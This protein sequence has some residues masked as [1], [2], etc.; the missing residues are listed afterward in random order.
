MRHKIHDIGNLGTKVLF[1]L[2]QATNSTIAK[3]VGNEQPLQSKRKNCTVI[4][5]PVSNLR[6]AVG[7][8]HLYPT[9]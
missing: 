7:T 1:S 8:S 2:L 6:T 3:C 9:K 5:S 4:S